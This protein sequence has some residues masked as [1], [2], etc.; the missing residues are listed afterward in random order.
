MHG[1]AE[2][3][4]V[5]SRP[6][7]RGGARS[8]APME[9]S[10]PGAILARRDGCARN[11]WILCRTAPSASQ[12]QLLRNFCTHSDVELVH[13]TWPNW[14]TYT[15]GGVPPSEARGAPGH[16]NF[17]MR[18]HECTRARTSAPRRLCTAREKSSLCASARLPTFVRDICRRQRP[19]AALSAPISAQLECAKAGDDDVWVNLC[20][21]VCECLCV[22]VYVVYVA[23]H[24]TFVRHSY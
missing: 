1:T 21:F 24:S 10:I 23:L 16:R 19:G 11:Q 18:A 8:V 9:T 2:R 15:S 4:R 6:G 12:A 14:R 20:M 5:R 17:P 3:S 7:S 22:F 13:S